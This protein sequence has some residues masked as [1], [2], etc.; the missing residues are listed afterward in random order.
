[1]YCSPYGRLPE[2]PGARLAVTIARAIV[3]ECTLWPPAERFIRSVVCYVRDVLYHCSLSYISYSWTAPFWTFREEVREE[4]HKLYQ[5]VWAAEEL[6]DSEY[7]SDACASDIVSEGDIG[8]FEGRED[9]D[10]CW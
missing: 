6:P 9:Q 2:C 4:C 5:H 7:G 1:M 8:E 3:L 10:D